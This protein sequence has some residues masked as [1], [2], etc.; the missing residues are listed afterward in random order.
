MTCEESCILCPL[1][2]LYKINHSYYHGLCKVHSHDQAKILRCIHCESNI[3]MIF[4]QDFICILCIKPLD[5]SEKNYG[6]SVC[7]ACLNINISMGFAIIKTPV[8]SCEYCLKTPEILMYSISCTHFICQ[9]CLKNQI[10]CPLC[11][12]KHFGSS[13][14]EEYSMVN[15]ESR[16]SK[17]KKLCVSEKKP[18]TPYVIRYR[19]K[20]NFETDK[21]RRS[22]NPNYNTVIPQRTKLNPTDSESSLENSIDDTK[23]K[24]SSLDDSEKIMNRKKLYAISSEDNTSKTMG[25]ISDRYIQDTYANN[26]SKLEH[27]EQDE[28]RI[29]ENSLASSGS[30]MKSILS[31]LCPCFIN[32]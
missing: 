14:S 8:S 32:N 3:P 7:M 9:D 28:A 13:I 27:S 16:E 12:L 6:K 29:S 22:Y 18:K 25:N 26:N 10:S 31:K 19:R 15:E 5:D 2:Q 20:L 17:H 4:L 24:T 21:V 11:V 23:N 30:V 1:S